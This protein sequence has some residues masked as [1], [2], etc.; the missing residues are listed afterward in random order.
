MRTAEK[1]GRIF[2]LL[3]ALIAAI[4]L[5]LPGLGVSVDIV[6]SGSMEP[7]LKTGALVFTDTSKTQP[8]I[9]DVIMFQQ[10]DMKITHRVVNK[11]NGTY[12]TK[13]DANKLEDAEAVKPSQVMGTVLGSIPFLGYG[14][15]FLKKKT[16][17]VILLLM[18]FQEFLLS[19]MQWK[20]ARSKKENL[21]NKIL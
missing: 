19:I 3:P 10:S 8:E 5:L 18:L 6:L 20:G 14:A 2:F 13:G 17:F 7:Y 21:R 11:E 1:L 9:G 15:M 4:L 16:I 12:I